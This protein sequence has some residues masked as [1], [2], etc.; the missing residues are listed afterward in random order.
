MNFILLFHFSFIISFKV[1][2]QRFDYI[3]FDCVAFRGVNCSTKEFPERYGNLKSIVKC[4]KT[5]N[6]VDFQAYETAASSKPARAPFGLDR[7]GGSRVAFG[8]KASSSV[9]PSPS[10]LPILRIDTKCWVKSSNIYRF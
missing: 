9:T 10:L 6:L 2:A 5:V 8:A 3:G 4:S 1:D 7:G